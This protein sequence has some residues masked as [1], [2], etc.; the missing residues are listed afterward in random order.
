MRVYD[1]ALFIFIF[2]FVSGAINGMGLFDVNLPGQHIDI[3]E[4]NV[5]EIT[6]SMQ[7]VDVLGVAFFMMAVWQVLGVILTAFT[8]ALT[9][10]P[11]L[12]QYSVPLEV[13]VMIQGP[14]WLVYVWGIL[15]YWSGRS[16]K[17]M[18]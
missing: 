17:G 4:A 1:I 11:L 15:Q 6:D 16:T 5:N 12:S 7:N 13:S 3:T 10:I 8:T 2:S 14:I 18:D 9:I